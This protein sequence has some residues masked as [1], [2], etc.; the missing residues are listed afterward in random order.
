MRNRNQKR[1]CETG[2]RNRVAEQEPET[3]WRNRNQKQVGET[4]TSNEDRVWGTQSLKRDFKEVC[5][6]IAVLHNSLTI[7]RKQKLSREEREGVNVSRPVSRESNT[8]STL[9]T[10]AFIDNSN[11]R[12]IIRVRVYCALIIV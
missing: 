10:L 9:A 8:S 6:T 5:Y 12:G 7:R 11:L 1:V 4:R 3:K 2:T